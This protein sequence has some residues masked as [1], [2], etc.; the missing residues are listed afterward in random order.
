MANDAAVIGLTYRGTDLQDAD[1]GIFLEVRRGLNEPPKVRGTDTVVPGLTGR[2]WRNRVADTR[3]LELVG[4]ISPGTTGGGGAADRAGFR[5]NVQT[6]QA[7][8]DPTEDPGDLVATLEDGTTATIGARGVNAVWN[9]ITP[10]LASVSF[11]LESVDPE[12][13]ITGS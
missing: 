9:Q 13:V 3:T 4:Y 5:A 6:V 12:W 7:L 10:E 8:F 2:Y 11:E 1:F